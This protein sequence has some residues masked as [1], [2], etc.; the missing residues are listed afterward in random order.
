M[1]NDPDLVGT[2]L[3]FSVPGGGKMNPREIIDRT[4]TE[5][6]IK[7]INLNSFSTSELKTFMRERG[8]GV[9]CSGLTYQ[10][11]ERAFNTLGGKDFTQRIVGIDGKHG[12]TKVNA[13]CLTSPINS[14]RIA[15]LE[16]IKPADIIRCRKG[17]HSITILEVEVLGGETNLVCAHSSDSVAAL[18]VSIFKI[19]V[20]SLK[21]NI[22]RQEWTETD[23]QGTPYNWK[24]VQDTDNEDGI[25]RLKIIH[26]LYQNPQS[27][28]PSIITRGN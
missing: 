25:Y 8:M 15:R 19:K 12:I 11:C 6:R 10:L 22:F 7:G 24:L 1:N 2:V 27:S 4:Y 16:E 21:D 3:Y 20:L 23:L 9:D 17:H 28:N 13:S 14:I 26:D 18:G 5:D